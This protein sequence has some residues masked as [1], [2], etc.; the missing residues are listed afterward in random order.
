MVAYLESRDIDWTKC[1]DT[2]YMKNGVFPVLKEYLKP[3]QYDEMI[4]S[5]GLVEPRELDFIPPAPIKKTTYET[6]VKAYSPYK[7]TSL[8][9]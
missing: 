6:R 9:Q 7:F 1:V 3:E 8:Y 2:N 4:Q 5:Y